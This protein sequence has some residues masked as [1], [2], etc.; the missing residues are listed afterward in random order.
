MSTTRGLTPQQKSTLFQFANNLI[1]NNCFLNKIGKTTSPR[2]SFCE[3]P[4]HRLHLLACPNS[5]GLGL[6]AVTILMESSK[7]PLTAQRLAVLDLDLHRHLVLPALVV[8]SEALQ[9]ISEKRKAGK[10]VK[11][12]Q[13]V[14]GLK[15]KAN[16]LSQLKRRINAAALIDDWCQRIVLSDCPQTEA[17]EIIAEM[18]TP[19]P[20]GV[21][22]SS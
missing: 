19:R 8:L 12:S 17:G 9:L 4:D 3:E 13:A 7:S 18:S 14:S 5:D 21:P 11:L 2:C 22:F 6:A 10:P 20:P 1:V 16:A 15:A